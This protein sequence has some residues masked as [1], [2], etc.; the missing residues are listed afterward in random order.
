MGSDDGKQNLKGFNKPILSILQGSEDGISM[1]VK[2]LRKLVLLAL[3]IDEDD[4]N[5]KKGFKKAIQNLEAEEKL[6]LSSDGIVTLSKSEKK[7]LEK[8][9]K[10]T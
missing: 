6:S 1:K 4:K 7:K 10:K 8:K 9:K 2:P 3:Q 5:S